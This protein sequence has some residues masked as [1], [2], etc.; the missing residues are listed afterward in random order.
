MQ[1]LKRS[2]TDIGC[3][4]D[5]KFGIEFYHAELKEKISFMVYG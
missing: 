1:E 2:G 3:N 5:L 4:P